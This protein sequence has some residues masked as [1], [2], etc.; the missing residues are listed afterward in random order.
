MIVLLNIPRVFLIGLLVSLVVSVIFYF[1]TSILGFSLLFVFPI[2]QGIIIGS[3]IAGGLLKPNISKSLVYVIVIV[4]A[5]VVHLVPHLLAWQ[6]ADAFVKEN[7]DSEAT[8]T[9]ENY[10]NIISEQ[11][12]EVGK[13]GRRSFDLGVAG[14]WGTEILNF[15]LVAGA[16][17][18][19]LEKRASTIGK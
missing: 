2:I 13:V 15:I 9:L 12:A 14:F 17:L 5:L 10:V 4:L 19:V 6:S 3:F 1:V 18:Y 16:I 7:F 8:V 11:G